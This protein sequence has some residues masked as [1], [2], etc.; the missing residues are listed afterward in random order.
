MPLQ[1]SLPAATPYN[2]SPVLCSDVNHTGVHTNRT[3]DHLFKETGVPE[4]STQCSHLSKLDFVVKCAQIWARV[5]D[6]KI[7]LDTVA[8]NYTTSTRL[9]RTE[10]IIAHSKK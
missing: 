6:V 10:E 1:S 3:Q 7:S 2:G 5:P 8:S 4:Y 9:F